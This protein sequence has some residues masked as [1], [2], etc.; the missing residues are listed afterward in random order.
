[1]QL[2]VVN[3]SETLGVTELD[4]NELHRKQSGSP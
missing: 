1:M 3:F 4:K 2:Q